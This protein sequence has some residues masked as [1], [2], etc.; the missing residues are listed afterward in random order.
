MY[1]SGFSCLLRKKVTVFFI[2]RREDTCI[3][4]HC[5]FLFHARGCRCRHVTKMIRQRKASFP[6][7]ERYFC[8]VRQ[9]FSS[10]LRSVASV[11]ALFLSMFWPVKARTLVFF[12]CETARPNA[13]YAGYYIWV[14]EQAWGQDDLILAK[15]F[16]LCVYTRACYVILKFPYIVM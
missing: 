9:F 2:A 16:F 1:K 11:S 4:I 5:I 7:I 12:F 8:A 15:F 3:T 10:T 6:F 13:C 14:I